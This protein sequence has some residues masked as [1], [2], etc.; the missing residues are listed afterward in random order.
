[1]EEPQ[2]LCNVTEADFQRLAY[3]AGWRTTKRGWP[4]FLCFGPAGEVI[5]VE[6]KPRSRQTGRLGLLKREQ[7]DCMDAL[8][9][10]GIR[11]FVSDGCTLE[12]YERSRH[13]PEWRRRG[14]AKKNRQHRQ[15]GTHGAP[16]PRA[17]LA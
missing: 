3:K 5:A 9:V 11:C 7:A 14:Q 15:A 13:A 10:R 16:T 12:P 17:S 4:D 8:K 2:L 6:V 1:L